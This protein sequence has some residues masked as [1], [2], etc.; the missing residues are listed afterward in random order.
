[1]TEASPPGIKSDTHSRLRPLADTTLHQIAVHLAHALVPLTAAAILT[2]GTRDTLGAQ[3]TIWS[4]SPVAVWLATRT[5]RAITT[6][7]LMAVSALDDIAVSLMLGLP[8]AA[9]LVWTPDRLN[10]RDIELLAGALHLPPTAVA[11]VR[12]ALRLGS[13]YTNLPQ[14][15]WISLYTLLAG[16]SVAFALRPRRPR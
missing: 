3:A 9:L 4:L 12:E 11:A 1:M 16:A 15:F 7:S 6:C 8:L 14:W 13:K 10:L 2:L 5:W